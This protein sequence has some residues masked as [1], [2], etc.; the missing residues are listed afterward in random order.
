MSSADSYY[1]NANELF[2]L[3]L[4]RRDPV[5]AENVTPYDR[6]LITVAKRKFC[7]HRHDLGYSLADKEEDL[8][9][10]DPKHPEEDWCFKGQF[11]L[12]EPLSDKEDYV[13]GIYG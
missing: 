5:E 2:I 8:S 12:T 3:C 4:L 11:K 1:V 6:S 10:F 13:I 7:V 9:W